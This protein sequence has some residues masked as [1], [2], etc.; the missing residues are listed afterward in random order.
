MFY[1][2]MVDIG[3]IGL[4]WPHVGS[5]CTFVHCDLLTGSHRAGD[6]FQMFPVLKYSSACTS[7]LP[8]FVGCKIS[9]M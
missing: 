6:S 8:A 2:Y 1:F 7:Q 4:N 9:Y 3:D 5:L